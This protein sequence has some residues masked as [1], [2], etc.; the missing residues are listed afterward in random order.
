MNLEFASNTDSLHI[1][2]NTLVAKDNPGKLLRI[3]RRNQTNP[4]KLNI[5]NNIFSKEGSIPQIYKQAIVLDSLWENNLSVN[6]LDHNLYWNSNP[7]TTPTIAFQ[8]FTRDW[9]YSGNSYYEEN[10]VGENPLLLSDYSLQY[11][12]PAKNKGTGLFAQVTKDKF[13]NSRPYWNHDYDAGAYEIEDTQFKI[14]VTG[15]GDEEPVTHTLTLLGSYWERSSSGIWILSSDQTLLTKSYTTTGNSDPIDLNSWQGWEYKWLDRDNSTE[16]RIAAGFYKLSNSINN[17]YIYLDLRDA[18]SNNSLNIYIRFNN[19]DYYKTYQ[20][21]RNNW[22]NNINSGSV[23][24]IWQIHGGNHN[25]SGLG[26]SYW[27]NVLIPLEHSLHP[28]MVWGPVSG[29][30]TY[31]VYHRPGV[32]FDW[33]IVESLN[34]LYEYT[35]NSRFLLQPGGPAGHTEYYRVMQNNQPSNI[36][37]FEFPGGPLDK[38]AGMAT[39]SYDISQ[40]YPNPFNPVTTIKFSI[41][42]EDWVILKVYDILGREVK[43]L[44][45]KDLKPGEYQVE[46]NSEGLASGIYI[47]RI[48]SG[49]YTQERKMQILK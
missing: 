27:A 36:V 2:N 39:I 13:G 47:Y 4:G 20:Y 46:F 15:V 22:N 28:R 14:G 10:G 25:T 1:F 5:K 7:K 31:S 30:S 35:D 29:Q 42:V 33:S 8:D 17:D 3:L 21:Y 26:T 19:N 40:N 11:H 41:A 12:S 32:T 18:V 49:A 16:K 23:I 9:N 6:I 24:R 43:T 45:D 38:A 48:I 34:N 37:G 44:I